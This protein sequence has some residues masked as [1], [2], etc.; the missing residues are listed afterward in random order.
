MK[1]FVIRQKST[2]KTLPP[3]RGRGNRGFTHVEP[4]SDFP[5]LFHRHHDARCALS[6]WLKGK[7]DVTYV[8]TDNPISGFDMHEDWHT[9]PVPS[10]NAEDMKIVE[11]RLVIDG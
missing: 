7:V 1:A 8:E 11:A 10:R 6:W 5:R 3:G 9:T 4:N 2:G